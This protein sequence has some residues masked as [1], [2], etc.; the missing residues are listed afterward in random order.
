MQ[1][2]W[3]TNTN[4]RGT[5]PL[6]IWFWI[7]IV[8]LIRVFYLEFNHRP[9]GIEEAQYWAWSTH[10]AWGY[11]SKGPLIAWLIHLSTL[12]NGTSEVGIR[13]FLPFLYAVASFMVYY[14]ADRLFDRRVAFFSALIFIF[15]P[16][17]TFSATVMTTD[18]IMLTCW[19]VALYAFVEA[20]YA[21][22]W[23]YWLLCGLAIGFGLL[24]KYTMGVFVLSIF[25]YVLFHRR[26]L[27]RSAGIYIALVVALLLL[28]PNLYWNAMHQWVT[29]SHVGGHN[30]DLQAA[31]VHW[32]HLFSFIGSQFGVAGPITFALL[33]FYLFR[34]QWAFETNGG[35]LLFWQIVPLLLAITVESFLSRA[36]ANWAA[37]VYVA[38]S[39]YVP[40]AFLRCHRAWL[41]W[42]SIALSIV[43][44]LTLYTYEITRA[45]GVESVQ[46]WV[47]V[48]P[49]KR[50]RVWP[51]LGSAILQIRLRDPFAQFVFD[52]RAIMNESMFYGHI[53][54]QDTFVFNPS[55][56]LLSQYDLPTHLQAG[57]NYYFVT[58]DRSGNSSLFKVFASH[59]LLSQ[60]MVRTAKSQHAFMIYEVVHFKGYS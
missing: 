3:Q 57:H 43:M 15:L 4:P 23:R 19:A 42:V 18:P 6:A 37:P 32:G 24:A 29:F 30:V 33:L 59:K 31:G 20:D 36:Y 13:F 27:L 9:L 17:V 25:L 26:D 58:A 41:L 8:T 40:A 12:M 50:N 46:Q 52:G 10:L 11:H 60:L 47:K 54:L 34:P 1:N 28:S 7:V 39:I 45:Y 5:G 56:S 48:D 38:A 51:Q 53:P 22:D 35:K 14:T 49:F 2:N 21:D 44:A 55:G 16:A